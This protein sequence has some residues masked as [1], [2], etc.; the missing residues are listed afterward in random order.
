MWNR[1]NQRINSALNAI[2][3]PFRARLNSIDSSGK[4]QTIQAEGLAKEPLQGQELFQQYGLTSNPPPGTMAVVIP[5]GGKTSHGIVVATEH[6]SYRLAGLK[7]G[8]VALYTDEGAKIVLKRGKIIET[9]CDVFRVNCKEFEVNAESKAD[10]N[11]PE[12]TTSQRLTAMEQITGNGGMSIKGGTGAD[13]E[14]NISQ[15]SGS[16][17]TDGDVKAGHISLTGHEHTNGNN[18]GNTG[19]PVG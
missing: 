1:I 14:G 15:T 17:T 6:G 11:T 9:D 7:S 8:E 12:V 18:G 16:Y 5:V 2:R 3:M 4:V 10:F 13:F 19:K